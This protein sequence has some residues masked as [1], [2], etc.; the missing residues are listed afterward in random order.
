M[1]ARYS[2][3]ARMIDDSFMIQSFM[4]Q[5]TCNLPTTSIF[6]S[7]SFVDENEALVPTRIIN[8]VMSDE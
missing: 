1:K 5:A 8:R 4:I 2:R 6:C 7:F 3:K